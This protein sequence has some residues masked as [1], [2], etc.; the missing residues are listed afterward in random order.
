MFK[1]YANATEQYITSPNWP[2]SYP[3]NIKCRWLIQSDEKMR[4]ELTVEAFDIEF[5]FDV[6]TVCC[7]DS[8]T[9]EESILIL[10]LVYNMINICKVSGN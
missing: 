7:V 9:L 4:V 8:F 6:L 10:L 5:F 1:L 2:S 3:N